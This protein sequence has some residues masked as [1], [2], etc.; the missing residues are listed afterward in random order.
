MISVGVNMINQK[1]ILSKVEEISNFFIIKEKPEILSDLEKIKE[2]VEDDTFHIAVVGEFSSGKSTFINAILG[3]DM[4]SH[5]VN[6]T[7]ATIT[8]IC[9]VNKTDRR[10]GFCEI[11]YHDGKITQFEDTSQ[12]K[13]YTT[14][15]EGDDVAAK[16]RSVTVYVHLPYI[17]RPITIVD[18][19]GLNGIADKHREITFEEVKKAHACVYIL[20][21]KGL[22]RVHIKKRA[23]KITASMITEI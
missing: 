6:E 21:G 8:R 11:L 1:Q 14:V 19:P 13:N 4:L 20:S 2:R 16:I 15:Q 23:S 17:S 12:L 7:T 9:H 22:Q 5:A 3:K 18:T 10:L